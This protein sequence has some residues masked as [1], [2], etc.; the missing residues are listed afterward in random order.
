[1]YETATHRDPGNQLSSD[2]CLEYHNEQPQDEGFRL[3]AIILLEVNAA[4]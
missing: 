2:H 1:M 3:A 4:F